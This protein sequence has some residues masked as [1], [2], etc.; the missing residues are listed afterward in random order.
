MFATQAKTAQKSDEAPW[1][2][3]TR[4]GPPHHHGQAVGV[5]GQGP[6]AALKSKA[7]A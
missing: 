2:R 5:A 4:F 3:N 7:P 1:M 6:D